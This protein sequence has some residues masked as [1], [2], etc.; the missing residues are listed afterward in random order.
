VIPGFRVQQLLRHFDPKTRKAS[1]EFP[2]VWPALTE[3]QL[4]Q[5]PGSLTSHVQVRL[6]SADL[7]TV[8]MS[9]TLYGFYGCST[10]IFVSSIPD[11]SVFSNAQPPLPDAFF[12]QVVAGHNIDQFGQARMPNYTMDPLSFTQVMMLQEDIVG[13]VSVEVCI[14]GR[15][16]A[17]T[18]PLKWSS[19]IESKIPVILEPA[20]QEWDYELFAGFGV[21]RLTLNHIDI[22]VNGGSATTSRF[23]LPENQKTSRIFVSYVQPGTDVAD[24][25]LSG[26]VIEKINGNRVFSLDDYRKHFVPPEG[27]PFT[28]ET[29][30]KY[31]FL[32]NFSRELAKQVAQ[33]KAGST[34]LYTKAVKKANG[35]KMLR[36]L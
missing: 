26:M 1:K 5:L 6:P 20:F 9:A 32:A 27:S 3:G 31:M 28:L 23:M 21:M 24:S 33:A 12:L 34:Y 35:G 15:K 16:S 25:L 36:D 13:N 29:D 22:I 7:K 18:V 17:H 19:D 8:P 4:K 10:G 2:T 11:T 14:N 30:Q